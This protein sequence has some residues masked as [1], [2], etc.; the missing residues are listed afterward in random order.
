MDSLLD[1]LFDGFKS[2][3]GRVVPKGSSAALVTGSVVGLAALAT[4]LAFVAF[5]N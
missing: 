5:Q 1:V 2:L 3:E 4:V